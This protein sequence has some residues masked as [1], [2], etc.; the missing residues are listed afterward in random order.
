MTKNTPSDRKQWQR[1][2][3]VLGKTA[4]KDLAAFQRMKY[5]SPD[6]WR[7]LQ[8]KFR[9]MHLGAEGA[10][11]QIHPA[12][13]IDRS[14]FAVIEPE[15]TTDEVVITDERLNHI[16][17]RHPGDYEAYGDHIP[18]VLNNPDAILRDSR[19]ATA[20]MIKSVAANDSKIGLRL[21]LRLHT[22]QDH[23]GYKNS[24]LSFQH[25]RSSEFRRLIAKETVIYKREGL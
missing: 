10:Q 8:A 1:Y 24:I 11:E 21:T 18:V 7:S 2:R 22:P 25:V 14:R 15:I 12:G 13:R 6:E 5:S 16:R 3:E 19:R 17:Q 4:P 9:R 20:V 23:A